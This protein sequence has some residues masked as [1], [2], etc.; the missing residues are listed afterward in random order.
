DDRAV[1]LDRWRRL[2]LDDLSAEVM[3]NNPRRSE[4]RLVLEAWEGR[5]SIDSA[6]YRL[7]WEIRLRIIR[8]A[9]SPLT[10]RCRAADPDFRLAGLECE[11][12]AWALV[13]Q[14][15]VHLLDPAYRN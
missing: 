11:P 5:A 15:P 2:L 8:A 4:L 9:L 3:A 12:A 14:R 10:A 7:V 13:T 6:A 1:F